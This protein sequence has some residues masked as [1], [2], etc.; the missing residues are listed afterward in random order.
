MDE[1]NTTIKDVLLILKKR[2]KLIVG[3]IFI[4][5]ISVAIISFF[6]ITP[7]YE[8][9]TKLFIGKETNNTKE[10]Q[11]GDV[12]MYQRLMKTYSE[13]ITTKDLIQNAIKDSDLDI[14]T[15]AVLKKL[16]V[17]QSTDTQ[18]LK[19]TYKNSDRV[20][21]KDVL[22]SITNRF[23]KQSK[24][25]IPNGTVQIIESV[26]LPEEPISP[27]R[28][29]NIAI[30]FILGLIGGIV[31]SLIVEYMNDTIKTKE[32]F[33]KMIKIPVIGIIPYEERG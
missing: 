27:N 1:T 23:I 10:Y 18:I 29:L 30:G 7:I 32:Q 28:Y 5:T 13:L 4:T 12:D 19:I 20:L 21:A 11:D 33:E 14:E 24:M 3:M 25:L 2:W 8:T 17:N 26:E 6:I 15:K 16:K 9:E 31:L 22:E